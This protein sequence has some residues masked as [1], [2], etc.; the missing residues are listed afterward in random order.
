[1]DA[2]SSDERHQHERISQA[3]FAQFTEMRSLTDGYS[4]RLPVSALMLAA[5]FVSRERLCCPF[6]RFQLEVA[7]EAELWLSL[8]GDEGAK[9]FIE[10]EFSAFV[11]QQ[12]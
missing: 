9:A 8:S 4:F 1:M 6:F 3:L 2:L 12:G 5:E 10:Q 7:P 11:P